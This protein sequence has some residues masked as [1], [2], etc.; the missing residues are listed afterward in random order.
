MPLDF[1]SR[2]S[3][4]SIPSSFNTGFSEVGGPATSLNVNFGSIGKKANVHPTIQLT[5]QGAIASAE[6]IA[7]DAITLSD[8]QAERNR[9]LLT[10]AF[11][12]GGGAFGFV[13]ELAR[14]NSEFTQGLYSDSLAAVGRVVAEQQAANQPAE[15]RVQAIARTALIAGAVVAAV[16]GLA[17]VARA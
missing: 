3:S 15:Q 11:D 1:S 17:W 7:A 13:G 14:A 6:R 8:R 4:T 9:E 2:S 12:F 10:T 5:D 16:L